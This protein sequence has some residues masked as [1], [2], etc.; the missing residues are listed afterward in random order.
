[1]YTKL[2]NEK[3][4]MSVR[5]K[6]HFRE[7]VSRQA[8]CVRTTLLLQLFRKRR[9]DVVVIAKTVRYEHFPVHSR[10]SYPM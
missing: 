1:M 4:V 9:R 6:V 5:D 8:H 3:N 7:T 2:K 10:C